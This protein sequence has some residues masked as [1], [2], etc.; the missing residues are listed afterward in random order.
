MSDVEGTTSTRQV[1]E[2]PEIRTTVTEFI[3]YEVVCPDCKK[4]HKTKF[5]KNVTQPMQYGENL[6]AFM[7]YLTNYQFLP[8]E[9]AAEI[10]SEIVGQNV[11]EGTLV[12]VNNRLYKSLE[13]VEASIKEQLIASKVVH[14]DETGLRSGGKTQWLHSASTEQLTHYEAHQKRGA[15][16]TKEIGILP[17]FEGTAVHD[18]WMPYYTF[19]NC[20]HSECNAHNG[21]IFF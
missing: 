3:T 11:S 20:S 13:E 14:F 18:H 16:A 5:P 17:K 19:D 2:M 12:N 15:E 6:Q 4:V 21:R 10:L 7:A 9:R 8:L 1:T